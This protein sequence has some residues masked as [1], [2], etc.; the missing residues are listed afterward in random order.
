[1]R[2]G[3]KVVLARA[4]FFRSGRFSLSAGYEY[5]RQILSGYVELIKPA[6]SNL[7]KGE[8]PKS[9]AYL[10]SEKRILT[11]KSVVVVGYEL[12]EISGIVCWRSK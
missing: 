1:M 6:S 2:P 4:L 5:K 7:P 10:F 12:A 9:A 3:S 8:E 11:P